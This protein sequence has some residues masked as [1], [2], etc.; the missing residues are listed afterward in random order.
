MGMTKKRSPSY[1]L[2][3]ELIVRTQRERKVLEKKMRI[4]K[5]I[6]NACLGYCLKRLRAVKA[7]H[8]YQQ[9]LQEPKSAKR[10]RGLREIEWAY[11]Y[12]E[13]QTHAFSK[14]PRAHFGAAL[15]SSVVQKLATRAFQA[16][17]RVHYFK[18]PKVRFKSKTDEMTVE[19]KSNKSGLRRR[20]GKIIWGEIALEFK[21]APQD[22]YAQEGLMDRTKYVRI[23][24]KQIRGQDRYFV[25]LVQEGIPP[26]KAHAA[27]QT[28]NHGR[29][30]IDLGTATVAIVSDHRALLTPLAPPCKK[31]YDQI[32]EIDQALLRSKKVSNP[33]NYDKN[34][35]TKKDCLWIYSKRYLKL[36]AKR[37]DLYRKIAVKQRQ[38]QEILAN[39]IL[40]L[41]DD[42][43]IETKRCQS[44]EIFAF[45]DTKSIARKTLASERLAEML[46]EIIQRK[47]SYRGLSVKKINTYLA[48]A[49]EFNPLNNTTRTKQL[50]QQWLDLKGERIH[51]DLYSAFLLSNT[52]ESLAVIDQAACKT[53]WDRFKKLHDLEIERLDQT[54]PHE[55]LPV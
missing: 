22:R 35:K 13:Y 5:S 27:E 9:L 44:L 19:N 10:N 6:Y 38:Y 47:L 55:L 23:L 25:Q 30:G 28:V 1:I 46:I 3:F 49:K 12:S 32:R 54:D 17:E 4:A 2:E 15:G 41:G 33:E 31:E 51:R 43:R 50:A 52:A 29:V 21:V 14:D 40:A 20:D 16:V 48:K 39:Q 34:G 36:K 18:T 53:K 24:R 37:N 8:E 26:Q 7:D 11:G 45:I 42:I